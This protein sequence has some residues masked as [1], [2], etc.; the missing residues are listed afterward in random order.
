VTTSSKKGLGTVVLVGI[1]VRL[2]CS[3]LP[4]E[5]AP[6]GEKANQSPIQQKKSA[7]LKTPYISFEQDL[8]CVAV[9][10]S[11][12]GQYKQFIAQ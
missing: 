2:L 8:L 9:F 3:N 5:I 11:F 4:K 12:E 10:F 7:G 1:R 6:W